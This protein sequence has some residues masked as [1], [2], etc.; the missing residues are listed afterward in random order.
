MAREKQRLSLF[1]DRSDDLLHVVNESHVEHA[2]GLVEDEDFQGVGGVTRPCSSGRA[3]ARRSDE[4]VRAALEG[5]YLWVL[6]DA[7]EDHWC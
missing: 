7:T 2:V 1:R 6:A 5:R 4:D 3:D